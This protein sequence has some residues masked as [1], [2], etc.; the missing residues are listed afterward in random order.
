MI[1]QLVLLKKF[2]N[3]SILNTQFQS[4]Q[5]PKQLPQFNLVGFLVEKFKIITRI[6]RKETLEIYNNISNYE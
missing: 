3:E 4:K 5:L 1:V 2:G 6:F